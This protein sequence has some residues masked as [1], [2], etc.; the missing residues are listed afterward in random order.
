MKGPRRWEVS[1]EELERMA[2][3]RRGGLSARSSLLLLLR[4]PSM[5]PDT[6]RIVAGAARDAVFANNTLIS[7]LDAARA[8]QAVPD[9]ATGV[10]WY[11]ERQFMEALRPHLGGGQRVLELGCGAGRISRHVAPLVAELVCT[12]RSGAM[13]AE[14]RQN[15]SAF[16]NI[17]VARTSGV[18]LTEFTDRAFALVFGQGVLGYL[19]PN[20]LL[21][22]LGEVR[23][24]L[25]AGG[26]CVFNFF[27]IDR[28]SDASDHLA[29]V[30]R[31][32]RTGRFHGGTD[33][34]YAAA[35]IEAL[36]RAAGLD[37]VADGAAAAGEAASGRAVRIGRAPND[38][39]R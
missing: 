11:D 38:G 31:Q 16:A 29:T 15:L 39:P 22:L 17:R 25:S 33:R 14:A 18:A 3:T 23:R 5:I 21:A 13:V 19:D 32:A 24:L 37:L 34:A 9:V 2:A 1:D 36:Y 7:L 28:Q 4:T 30:T 6:A 35:Q 27:T 26:L 12:D 8:R 10:G 20:P